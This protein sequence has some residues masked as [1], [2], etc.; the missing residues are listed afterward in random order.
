MKTSIIILGCFRDYCLG[1]VDRWQN[2]Y[3]TKI[4][5]WV[6]WFS[7]L[8]HGPIYQKIVGTYLGCAFD[9]WLGYV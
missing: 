8:E 4:I 2:K 7:W 6:R 3:K 9:P 1:L 5:A